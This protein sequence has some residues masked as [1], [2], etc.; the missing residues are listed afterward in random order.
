MKQMGLAYTMYTDD[1]N[2]LGLYMKHADDSGIA[3][4]L[5]NGSS[6][7]GALLWPSAIY[8]YVGDIKAYDCPS[9]VFIWKGSYSGSMDY[10]VNN[11]TRN[12]DKGQFKNP[13]SLMLFAE[14]TGQDS[15]ICN[16]DNN[17]TDW[18]GGY[19]ITNLEMKGAQNYRHGDRINNTYGD[20]HVAPIKITAIPVYPAYG[21]Q[22]L[23]WS[24]TYTGTNP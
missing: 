24:P 6:Y 16:S 5:P 22:G 8:S 9:S 14:A 17:I 1:Y 21:S 4:T 20:G 7:T 2:A 18:N 23:Y 12:I 3:Y 10:G 19:S 11:Y 13:S 15:Y